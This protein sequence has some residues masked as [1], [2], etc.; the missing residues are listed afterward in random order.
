MHLMIH[1]ERRIILNFS[2]LIKMSLV[3]CICRYDQI[4]KLA[5]CCFSCKRTKMHVGASQLIYA[6]QLQNNSFFF[7]LYMHGCIIA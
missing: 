2:C 1:L 7:L 5:N 4:I 3:Y 6:M